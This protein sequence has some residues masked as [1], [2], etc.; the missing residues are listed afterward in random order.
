MPP[1]HIC[2][3]G[4]PWQAHRPHHH[5]RRTHTS[6]LRSNQFS[7][8]KPIASHQWNHRI[9]R[10]D[11]I[12]R[13][14]EGQWNGKVLESIYFK[15]TI[16]I[17]LNSQTTNGKSEKRKN[18]MEKKFLFT[19]S[20]RMAHMPSEFRI[21]LFIFIQM[22]VRRPRT[23]QTTKT[24]I[25]RDANPR[26]NWKSWRVRRYEEENKW[27]K[28]PQA[29]TMT[30]ARDE[31]EWKRIWIS[32]VVALG[33]GITEKA[34][35]LSYVNDAVRHRCTLFGR[36]H[37]ERPFRTLLTLLRITRCCHS[38]IEHV[39]SEV[40]RVCACAVCAHDHDVL[41]H[42][43]TPANACVSGNMQK[44][45]ASEEERQRG[46]L[47]KNRINLPNEREAFF[48]RSAMVGGYCCAL[49]ALAVVN[50]HKKWLFFCVFV[51]FR[52]LRC[53]TEYLKQ[54]WRRD[55]CEWLARVHKM[56]T[57]NV[58]IRLSCSSLRMLRQQ[59]FCDKLRNY[60]FEWALGALECLS[61]LIELYVLTS[62]QSTYA[63]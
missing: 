15:Y 17:V 21:F 7:M 32:F 61:F 29:T 10:I 46:T 22:L 63:G 37:G 19:S 20:S 39:P 31:G 2:S 43:R 27:Q 59:N 5:R 49:R 55:K 36:I 60:R 8:R 1:P 25:A 26:E 9:Q 12:I 30:S 4:Q 57:A 23:S 50:L 47:L 38:I 28:L 24:K 42:R 54:K 62:R 18:R 40:R 53:R 14:D 51:A 45:K 48:S 33:A 11:E 44:T 52:L 34:E 56:C 41:E 3:P 58:G 6:R 13:N 35:L 16:D